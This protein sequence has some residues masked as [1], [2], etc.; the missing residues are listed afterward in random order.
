MPG[1]SI[2]PKRIP[3]F[4]L[5]FFS[6]SSHSKYKNILDLYMNAFLC[7]V[8]FYAEQKVR[9]Q[10]PYIEPTLIRDLIN[11]ARKSFEE[12]PIVLSVKSPCIVVGD[13]HGQILDLFRI[14]NIFGL[15]PRQ[16]Y[17]FL[18]DFVDRGEF[19]IEV[20]IIVFILKV[21]YPDNV[22]IIRG[23]HEFEFLSSQCGFMTQMIEFFGDN[24][25]FNYFINAFEYLPL[26]AK[27]DNQ[28]LCVH[29]GIGPSLKSLSQ[30]MCLRRPIS[31][32]GEEIL[33]SV[34][35]S[36]PSDDI[37]YFTESTR[38]TGYFFGEKATEEFLQNN[39]IKMIIRGHECVNNGC[40]L[41]FN[42]QLITVFSASNY[43]G[44]VNNQAGVLE[45]TGPMTYKIRQ[46]PPLTWLLRSNVIFNSSNSENKFI[47]EP[48]FIK[49][50]SS[51][52]RGLRNKLK[53][54]ES[55]KT[56]PKFDGTM[57]GSFN[58]SQ[59]MKHLPKLD[60]FPSMQY[61][62]CYSTPKKI[63]SPYSNIYKRTSPRRLSYS[64]IHRV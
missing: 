15:P 41:K 23:N 32:Y 58:A 2:S 60:C 44:L 37:D 39:N 50:S 16:K 24:V 46:F 35:W 63:I 38:G 54:A 11:D 52:N 14:L 17:V 20:I 12:E 13:L 45:I 18:G 51:P 9:L 27:I 57:E 55:T 1:K 42:N 61:D 8:S 64:G 40:E 34:L 47:K 29:G 26:A 62:V 22:N 4:F 21:L 33:D 56:L 6:L 25:L 49:P 7:D 53:Q 31:D 3:I 43:C 59:S 5:M 19:S 10:L 48:S 30:I 28:M 36:D